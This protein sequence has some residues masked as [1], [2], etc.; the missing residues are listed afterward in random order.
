MRTAYV[1]VVHP[2][3][4]RAISSKCVLEEIGFTVVL[5]P[6]IPNA[7][8]LLS[9]RLSM[10]HIYRLVRD[11][12]EPFSYIFEDD[13][14]ILE[15]IRLDEIMEY[16]PFT[17]MFFYLGLCE[18]NP[19]VYQ[20]TYVVQTHPVFVKKGN[21]RGLHAIGLSKQGAAALLAFSATSPFPYMDMVL[22]DFSRLYPAPV[23]RYDLESYIPGHRGILFQDRKRF[24]SE[25]A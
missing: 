19:L 11:S 17:E 10:Q 15:P 5:V 7:D 18:P 22:E 9:N 23:V 3:S 21:S 1:L 20:T 4:E 25:I 24:P 13:I 12:P 14:N 6:C 8:K 16:E 2:D